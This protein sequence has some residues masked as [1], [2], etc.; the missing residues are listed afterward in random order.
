MKPTVIMTFDGT[1]DESISYLYPYL[2]ARNIP[3]SLL[4][5][6]ARTLTAA[7]FDYIIGLRIA[8][9]WDIGMYGCNPNREIL[10]QD[11]NYRN[12]YYYQPQD[13][14]TLFGTPEF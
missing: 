1:Y 12:Q 11:D 14:K 10:T 2:T 6:S 7:A 3:C 13:R 5:S 9:G 8:H 4:L